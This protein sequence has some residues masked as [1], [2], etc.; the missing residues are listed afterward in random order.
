MI[1][2]DIIVS[3]SGWVVGSGSNIN[4]WD[5]PWLSLSEQTRPTG[6]AP[7]A[8]SQMMVSDLFIEDKIEWDVEKIRSILPFEEQRILAIKPSVTGAPDKLIWLHNASGEFTTKS[9]YGA[10]SSQLPSFQAVQQHDNFFN[11]KKNVWKLHVAPKI[12]LFIWKIFHGALPVGFQL[13]ARQINVEGK[14]KS[15]GFLECRF[16]Q[17]VWNCAPVS[18]GIEYSGSIDLKST[19]ESWIAK[20]NLPPTGVVAGSLAP[21]I[22]WQ[23]WITRNK[24]LFE[25]RRCS[26][27]E[28]ITQATIIAREW[29]QS[30]QKIEKK[31]HSLAPPPPQ[32]QCAVLRTDA[33]WNENQKIAGLGWTLE[34]TDGS[35]SSFA[36]PATHVHSPL[37]AEGLAM[38]EAV[39]KCRDLGVA[40]VRCESDSATLIKVL[41]SE[42]SNAELYGVAADVIS[43]SLSFECISFSWISRERNHVAD[44]LAKQAL[45]VELALNA[46]PNI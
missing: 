46:P 45:S 4:L 19:W 36:T 34:K 41:K 7:E 15:C 27:E 29:T 3:N 31:T 39:L 43:L 35:F 18:P 37:L 38:R 13:R 2:R 44:S 26:A 11:W 40:R 8:T 5:S 1:G 32:T 25:E 28:V 30:Q 17:Q 23:I 10:V 14:C 16:A 9:G 20:K 33:A 22:L 24:L 21:W 6:P 12:K 42:A